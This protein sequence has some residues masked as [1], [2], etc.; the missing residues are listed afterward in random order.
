MFNKKYF[1]FFS[2]ILIDCFT[3]LLS[4]VVAFIFKFYVFSTSFVPYSFSNYFI[5]VLCLIPVWLL[6]INFF[7]KYK[8]FYETLVNLLIK[9]LKTTV[10]FFVFLFALIFIVKSDFSRLCLLF[11]WINLIF[12]TFIF[13]YIFK[14]I[15]A[16]VTYK[17]N[18]RNNIL[19]IGKRVRK[20]K[21]MFN[22]NYINKVYYYPYLLDTNNIEKLKFLSVK[23]YIKEI[24]I[25]N[26][27]TEDEEFLSLCAWAQKNNIDIKILPN[28]VQM[29]KDKI[30]LD[31]TLGVPIILLTCNPT[32]NFDYFIKR[33]MDIVI[34]FILIIILSPLFLIIAILIKLENNGPIIYK[35]YRLGFN[36]KQF[37]CYKFRSMCKDANK[38]IKNLIDNSLKRNSAF[39]K[40]EDDIRI[41]KIGKFIRKYS[42]DELPQLF[43]VLKGEM[44]LVGPRPIVNW[45]LEQ[46]KKIYHNY[47]YD[48]MFRVFPGITGLWQVSGRSMLSDE[49]RLELEIFYV[50]NWSLSLD[51]KILLKTILVV[52]F[53]RGAY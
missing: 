9:I 7:V 51:I 6:F 46:I 40:L 13:R 35:H 24:I 19:V 5:Y 43:N 29:T 26:Y 50:D 22:N 41:T 11:A 28:E 21:K 34:S 20:Y 36:K 37:C 4:F 12:F 53:H 30:V 10:L 1:Y 39:L 15:I 18:I 23:K 44:S 25:I 14:R 48:K 32:I 42:L 31:D 47:S 8:L 17:L 2:Y 38:K 49:K 3:F 16:Y 27:L 33:L 52:I 45:E